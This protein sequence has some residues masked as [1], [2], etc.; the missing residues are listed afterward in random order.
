MLK[1]FEKSYSTS[2]EAANKNRMTNER[3]T[4]T[5][6]TSELSKK[7]SNSTDRAIIHR[8]SI[9]D[10]NDANKANNQQGTSIGSGS[11]TEI[12]QLNKVNMQ[13]KK[14]TGDECRQIM[15]RANIE[16]VAERAA[17]FEDI[18]LEKF[19][20]L[21]SKFDEYDLYYQDQDVN[22]QNSTR[23]QLDKQ[24]LRMLLYGYND[25]SNSNHIDNDGLYNYAKY[26]N[27]NKQGSQ[28][29]DNENSLFAR[30]FHPNQFYQP[31]K[32][33]NNAIML[34]KTG[35]KGFT[36]NCFKI[37]SVLLSSQ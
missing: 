7:D 26:M 19:N 16:T 11:S 10:I 6:A 3:P 17:H 24:R 21:K 13:Q 18:D 34:N 12:P 32:D 25:E 36:L 29:V 22:N 1:V 33:N 15:S 20:R 5:P 14:R 27:S 30:E 9:G 28:M 2:K 23:D 31:R 8:S 4:S 35:N 37:Y